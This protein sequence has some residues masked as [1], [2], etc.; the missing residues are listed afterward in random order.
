VLSVDHCAQ[1]TCSQDTVSIT[2]LI[3]GH[4][5]SAVIKINE[6]VV[7]IVTDPSSIQSGIDYC[8]M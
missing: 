6:A 3:P 1:C 2:N 4:S 7:V 8:L 5:G